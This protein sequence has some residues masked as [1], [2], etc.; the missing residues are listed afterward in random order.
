MLNQRVGLIVY[1]HRIK[2]PSCIYA[3]RL[4]ARFRLG[5]PFTSGFRQLI[6]VNNLRGQ[7]ANRKSGRSFIMESLS[8]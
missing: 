3:A 8:A 4:P 2:A 1:G 5:K 7:T 6:A